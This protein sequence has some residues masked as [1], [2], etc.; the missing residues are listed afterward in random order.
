MVSSLSA[1]KKVT[2]ENECENVRLLID[3]TLVRQ[4]IVNLLSNAIKFSPPSS[5]I[6]I[7]CELLAGNLRVC[8]IDQGPGISAEVQ[9]RLFQKFYQS[10]EGKIVGGAGLG[11]AIAKMIVDAHRGTIGV[12]SEPGTGS[13][14]WVELPLTA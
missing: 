4:V 10:A 12:N 11:L 13:T 14:F 3:T 5:P 9:N 8:V 6:T 2:I 7:K 1:F